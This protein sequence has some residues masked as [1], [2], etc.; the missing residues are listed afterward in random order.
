MI[1]QTKNYC[2][3]IGITVLF[4]SDMSFCQNRDPTIAEVKKD[5]KRFQIDGIDS[6][7]KKEPNL[8]LRLDQQIKLVAEFRTREVPAYLETKH[9]NEAESIKKFST[10]ARRLVESTKILNEEVITMGKWIEG[11]IKS[12]NKDLK[13]TNTGFTDFLCGRHLE[14]S[15]WELGEKERDLHIEV[16]KVKS[17]PALEKFFPKSSNTSKVPD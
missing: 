8:I 17:I 9:I 3:L 1:G 16:D 12:F 2:L 7:F 15:Y 6:F 11:A 14:K 5:C 13:N 4:Y 10:S